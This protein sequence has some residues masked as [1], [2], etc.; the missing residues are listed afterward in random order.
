MKSQQAKLRVNYIRNLKRNIEAVK[1][2]DWPEE[3]KN[4]TL[5]IYNSSLEKAEKQGH[6]TPT[7]KQI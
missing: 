7:K 6:F 5:I 2:S 1:L 3:Q 4:A